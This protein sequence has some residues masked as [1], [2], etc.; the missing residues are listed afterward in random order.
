MSSLM[1]LLSGICGG[2]DKLNKDNEMDVE[3]CYEI[4]DNRVHLVEK[5]AIGLEATGGAIQVDRDKLMEEP[6]I[7]SDETEGVNCMD[8]DDQIKETLSKD[9][10]LEEDFSVEEHS[11][12]IRCVFEENAAEVACGD[13][14]DLFVIKPI[15]DDD[16]RIEVPA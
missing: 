10:C 3:I 8:E 7:C 6:S 2:T 14:N 12:G 4:E 1:S 9:T 11:V 13:E 16:D 15:F 5:P